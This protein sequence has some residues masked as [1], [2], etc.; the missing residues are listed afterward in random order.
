MR[1]PRWFPPKRLNPAHQA[2]VVQQWFPGFTASV[3]CGRCVFRGTLQPTDQGERYRVHIRYRRGEIPRV[4]VMNPVIDE[5]APHLHEDG[6]LCLFHPKV[7]HWH[8]G[9]LVAKHT[10]PWTAVWLYFY[11]KWLELGVW[12]GPEAPH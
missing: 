9:R 5:D 6:S 12:F 3:T 7:F 11:E 10:I 1:V 4:H 8:D 2:L